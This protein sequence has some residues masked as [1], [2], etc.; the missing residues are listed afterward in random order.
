[1]EFHDATGR[2]RVETRCFDLRNRLRA[3][4]R[5]IP[6]LRMLSPSRPE[7]S[8]AI[9]TVALKSGRARDVA[10]RLASEHRIVVKALPATLIVDPPLK[11]EDYNALRFSTHVFNSEEEI[12]RAADVLG[13][14]LA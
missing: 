12:D 3:R 4:L 14:L 5:A 1:M 2:D 13:K 8:S 9:L 10:E 7:L 6:S 11:S